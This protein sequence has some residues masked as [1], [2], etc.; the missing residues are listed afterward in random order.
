MAGWCGN[1]QRKR[2]WCFERWLSKALRFKGEGE[3]RRRV[4]VGGGGFGGDGGE[5]GARRARRFGCGRNEFEI[6]SDCL[7]V[8]GIYSCWV[9]LGLGPGVSAGG[10]ECPGLW[11][12]AEFGGED[13]AGEECESLD[14]GGGGAEGDGFVGG[15][16]CSEE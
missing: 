1:V 16:V 4:G 6:E 5:A 11:G 13:D 14:E 15:R 3:N 2:R 8:L 10:E 7:A 12:V 9:A